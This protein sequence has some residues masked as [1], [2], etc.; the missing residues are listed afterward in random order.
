MKTNLDKELSSSILFRMVG[1]SMDNNTK[2]CYIDGDIL[3]CFEVTIKEIEVKRSYVINVNEACL[4]GQVTQVMDD[5]IVI[6]PLN[7]K[8]EK[9]IINKNEIDRIYFI[10][11]YDRQIV[12]DFRI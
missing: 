1:D 6:T 9:R 4:V 2:D 5:Y 3:R 10:K 12:P 8:Y 11:A 7:Q